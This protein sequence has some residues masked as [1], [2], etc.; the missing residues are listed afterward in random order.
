MPKLERLMRLEW[1]RKEQRA[2]RIASLGHQENRKQRL[3]LRMYLRMVREDRAFV[4]LA[5]LWSSILM[6]D[7][8]CD[9]IKESK[10]L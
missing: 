6:K 4:F 9:S 2:G 3:F 7:A 5:L 10:K 8:E 1:Q